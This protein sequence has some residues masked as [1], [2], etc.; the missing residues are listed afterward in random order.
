[1]AF[2]DGALEPFE[3]RDFPGVGDAGRLIVH[4]TS[5][6]APY[7]DGFNDGAIVL[8]HCLSC[9][10]ARNPV[11]PVCPYCA[12]SRHEWR[13]V[14]PT[15]SVFSWIRYHKPY[16]PE[17][18]PL[19]PYYVISA[20]LDAGPRIMGRLASGDK[21]TIGMRVRAIGERWADGR[22]LPAFVAA[23]VVNQA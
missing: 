1:M 10:K 11:A 9:G 16:Q 4:I 23:A 6:M 15:G 13:P 18:E 12:A 21:P 2:S 19:M 14:A 17:F 8:Q 20:E 7:W 3:I 22:V 5:D